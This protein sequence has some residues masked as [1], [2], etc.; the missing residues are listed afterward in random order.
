MFIHITN[1][2]VHDV[3]VLD[4]LCSEPGSIYL[5]D[6]GYLDFARLYALNQNHAY[7]VI[8]L[9]RNTKYERVYSCPVDKST[10]L[11]CDQTIKLTNADSAKDYPEH[12]RR[13]SYYDR[14][15]KRRFDY[16]TNH[17]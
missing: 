12:L 13:V 3:N 5:M 4:V 17:F 10:G 1:G 14:E 11:R 8:R 2:K 16:L 9:K 15:K 6:R 7:F